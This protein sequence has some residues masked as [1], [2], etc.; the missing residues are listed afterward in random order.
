MLGNMEWGEGE[1]DGKK[2]TYRST[3]PW[4]TLYPKLSS[5]QKTACWVSVSMFGAPPIVLVAPTPLVV[6]VPAPF[7]SAVPL[8]PVP[9]SVTVTAGVS[10]CC[11]CCCA[12]VEA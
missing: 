1:G 4:P 5:R 12:V 11:C 6:T 8:C 9:L 3:S 10:V 2:H 7:F